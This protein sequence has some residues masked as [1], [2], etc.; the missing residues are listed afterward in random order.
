[1]I[2]FDLDG[3]LADIGHRRHLVSGDRNNWDEFFRQCVNDKPIAP[4]ITLFKA[5]RR[6]GEHLQIWSGR[7]DIV[8]WDTR[9]WLTKH[10]FEGDTLWYDP[11]YPQHVPLRMRKRGDNTP[12]AVLKGQWLQEVLSAGYAIDLVVD[13]RKR[14]VE[15]WRSRGILTLQ[16]AEGEY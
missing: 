12:D 14:V 4:V 1:M 15:M 11:E 9:I 6:Q 7:S 10:V 5:L 13:D 3:T 8:L 2:I 16:C